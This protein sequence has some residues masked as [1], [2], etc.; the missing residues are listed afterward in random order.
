MK[1]TNM[2]TNKHENKIHK[3]IKM[4]LVQDKTNMNELKF[5]QTEIFKQTKTLINFLF[6]FL[7]F[8]KK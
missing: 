5:K 2:K 4:K 1:Q 8:Q 3:N 7:F 6:L